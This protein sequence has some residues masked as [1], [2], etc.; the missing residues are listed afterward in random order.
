MMANFI[1]GKP[2]YN[3]DGNLFRSNRQII[4]AYLKGEK[5]TVAELRRVPSNLIIRLDKKPSTKQLLNNL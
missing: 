4:L 5:V 2:R 1:T 3:K